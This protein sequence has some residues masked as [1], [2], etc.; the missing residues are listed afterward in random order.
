MTG[1]D[2]GEG[3]AVRKMFDAGADAFGSV[4]GA[5]AGLVSGSAEAALLGAFA[6]PVFASGLR[7]IA[8]RTLGRRE[9]ARVA[10]TYA[11]AVTAL[12]EMRQAGRELRSDGFFEPELGRRARAEEV[13]EGV[14]IAAQREHEELKLEHYGYLLANVAVDAGIDLHTANW[15]VHTAQEL[16]WTQLVLLRI[17]GDEAAVGELPGNIGSNENNWSSWTL[18]E[19]LMDLGWGHRGLI[20]APSTR[21]PLTGARVPNTRLGDHRLASG[22][23]LLHDL[24]WL[25][26]VR[27][28][29]VDAVLAGLGTLDGPGDIVG[30]SP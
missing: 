22:G 5:M 1:A 27:Q 20:T 7:E 25:D 9:S 2:E 8:M 21:T 24:M 4:F 10:L 12:T 14:L 30:G 15:A 11:G 26:R 13:V 17:V 6:G 28:I 29:E 16:S 18:H 23:L 19:E 3:D